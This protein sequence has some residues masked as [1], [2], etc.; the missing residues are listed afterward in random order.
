MTEKTSPTTE[1][2]QVVLNM[3]FFRHVDE[4]T[5]WKQEAAVQQAIEAKLSQ[6]S[7]LS[8]APRLYNHL[9]T[10]EPW[11][12]KP[13]TDYSHLIGKARVK[14]GNGYALPIIIKAFVALLVICAMIYFSFNVIAM[15]AGGALIGGMGVM[16]WLSLRQ[17]ELAI[18]TAV[19]TATKQVAELTAKEQ[20]L[21]A[22]QRQ[23][24]ERREARRVEKLRDLLAGDPDAVNE[25]VYEAVQQTKLPFLLQVE[26]EYYN[27]ALLL[28]PWF[29][30]PTL[31][32]TME[33]SLRKGEPPEYRQKSELEINKQHVELC[34]AI[35]LQ[36]ALNVLAAIPVIRQ[37][38]V[39]G[40]T[41]Y[42]FL[43]EE[44]VLSFRVNR[45]DIDRVTGARSARLATESLERHICLDNSAVLRDVPPLL[46]ETW[47]DKGETLG[48]ILF[49]RIEPQLI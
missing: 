30:P 39:Q 10:L 43:G 9:L 2:T 19:E 47:E 21:N 34:C 15:T 41:K 22:Q 32:P 40:M 28:K 38:S 13:L 14:A 20:L 4:E 3:N 26:T 46:P 17:R 36:L 25:K 31:F 6:V 42:G 23:Q 35:S 18:I 45:S 12:E 44:C 48:K 16:V 27:N 29:P 33:C 8:Y 5:R 24:H 1:D 37:V 11:K 7:R 49:L